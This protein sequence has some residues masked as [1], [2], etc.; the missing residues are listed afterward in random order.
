MGLDEEVLRAQKHVDGLNF[1]IDYG[2]SFFETT[3]RY[4]GGL[5]SAYELSGYSGYL[6]KASELG[7]LLGHNFG[8]TRYGLPQSVFNP[9]TYKAHN[10]PWNGGLCILSEVGSS[11]LEFASLSHHINNDTL[12]KKSRSIFDLLDKAEKTIP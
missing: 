9:H 10:H 5:L 8:T 1:D 6:K 7:E 12:A 4:F 11:Q 2:I 3:I